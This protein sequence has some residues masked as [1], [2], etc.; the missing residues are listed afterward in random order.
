VAYYGVQNS[1]VQLV[2][3]LTSPGIPDLYQGSELWELNLGDPDSRRPVDYALRTEQLVSVRAELDADRGGSMRKYFAHWRDGSIKMATIG[4]LLDARKA[5]PELFS[6]GSYEPLTCTG[7]YA[8]RICAFVRRSGEAGMLVAAKLFPATEQEPV[9]WQETRI[10]AVLG[11]GVSPDFLTNRPVNAATGNTY[12]AS[13]L[14]ADLPVN[15][16]FSPG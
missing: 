15:V 9:G 11:N 13:D 5:K 2:L 12:S 6:N 10:P 8:D 14:F 16:L 3:K 1:L 4:L 7:P